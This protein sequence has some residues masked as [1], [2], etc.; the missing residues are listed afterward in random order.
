MC[1]YVGLIMCNIEFHDKVYQ[2]CQRHRGV[3]AGIGVQ[4]Q[5]ALV[6]A[7]EIPVLKESTRFAALFAWSDLHPDE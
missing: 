4:R 7:G 3:S 5:Q 6:G 1:E 2:K